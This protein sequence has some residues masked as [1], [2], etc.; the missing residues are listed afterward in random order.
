MVGFCSITAIICDKQYL[1]HRSDEAGSED[2]KHKAW[3]QFEHE[4]IEPQ[5][6]LEHLLLIT[7]LNEMK[8][9]ATH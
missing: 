5:V 7:I 9:L 8:V 1:V 2:G 3:D 4:P 6:Q